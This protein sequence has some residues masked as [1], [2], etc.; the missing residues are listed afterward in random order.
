LKSIV[1]LSKMIDQEGD[2]V[3]VHTILK[4]NLLTKA[5]SPQV[6]SNLCNKL[7]MLNVYAPA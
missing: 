7:G 3:P 1:I 2:Y 5:A 4:A 6:F